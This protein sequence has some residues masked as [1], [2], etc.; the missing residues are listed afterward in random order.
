MSNAWKDLDEWDATPFREKY[1]AIRERARLRLEASKKQ[2]PRMTKEHIETIIDMMV[3]AYVAGECE[4]AQCHL[5][6]VSQK[7]TERARKAV[8]ARRRK[9]KRIAI[10]KA[11]Q[12]A[13]AQRKDVSVEQ[14][15]KEHGVSR[16]TAYR[17]LAMTAPRSKN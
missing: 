1:P 5:Q 8:V 7:M 3:G 6:E 16:A 15:A 11:F 14:L 10:V 17:A 12:A 2:L 9:S 4:T 13:A